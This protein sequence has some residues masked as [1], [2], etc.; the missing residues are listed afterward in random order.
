MVR[1]VL[2]W[3][4]MKEEGNALFKTYSRVYLDKENLE[5]ADVGTVI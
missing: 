1:V 4:T 2:K 5:N 3:E